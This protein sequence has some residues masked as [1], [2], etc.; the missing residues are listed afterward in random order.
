MLEKV[1]KYKRGYSVIA[2]ILV[3][4]GLYS[5]PGPV[6][7]FN[8]KNQKT[9]YWKSFFDKKMEYTKDSSQAV[10]FCYEYYINGDIFRYVLPK[11]PRYSLE[12]RYVPQKDSAMNNV[13]FLNGEVLYYNEKNLAYKDEFVN[14]V[15]TKMHSY[16]YFLDTEKKYVLYYE[17]LIDFTRPY[18]N[19]GNSYYF[20]KRNY[21]VL[22]DKWSVKKSY[23][24]FTS[25]RKQ[26]TIRL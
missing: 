15:V 5:Q 16:S 26:K 1:S 9:G 20:E 3:C 10:Y 6:N 18:N 17:E 12:I 24:I 7:R 4:F 25:K 11:D 8:E 22:R 14:G 21:K 19:N 13:K 23:I 2:F